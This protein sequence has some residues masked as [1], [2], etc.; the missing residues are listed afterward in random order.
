MFFENLIEQTN[1]PTETNINGLCSFIR[2]SKHIYL[3]PISILGPLQLV[4]GK[5]NDINYYSFKSFF[6]CY[7]RRNNCDSIKERLSSFTPSFSL[8]LHTTSF[9][10]SNLQFSLK[11]SFFSN[12]DLIWIPASLTILD[13]SWSIKTLWR[14]RA[15]CPSDLFQ[16]RINS[17]NFLASQF[18]HKSRANDLIITKIIVLLCS[19]IIISIR[20]VFVDFWVWSNSTVGFLLTYERFVECEYEILSHVVCFLFERLADF[21]DIHMFF[22]RKVHLK[23]VC[24]KLG[25]RKLF[26][27]FYT[28]QCIWCIV[29]KY[30]PN[31]IS[32]AKNTLLILSIN[33]KPKK[34][35]REL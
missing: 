3:K 32:V 4:H 11:I 34:Y 17:S 10:I 12:F 9:S 31:L 30:A 22:L 13:D 18:F 21:R 16:S 35:V 33:K 2:C 15:C 20:Y 5:L 25:R 27:L 26:E 14:T 19:I 28:K 1:K 23:V 6:N 7:P 8:F 24:N 29:L